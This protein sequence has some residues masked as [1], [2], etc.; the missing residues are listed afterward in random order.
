MVNF[1]SPHDFVERGFGYCVLYG[2]DIVSIAST[3]AVCKRESKSKS[4][5][6]R[7]TRAKGWQQQ[8]ARNWLSTRLENGLDPN[9]DA[10][11]EKSGSLAK[12]LGYTP[13]GTYTMIAYIKIR[14][15][16][17]LLYSLRMIRKAFRNR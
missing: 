1:S 10:A 13:Q 2:E 6:R 15:F 3:F 14:S 12:K 4:T 9:W 8:Q 7:N 11:T 16:Y 5:R 17:W